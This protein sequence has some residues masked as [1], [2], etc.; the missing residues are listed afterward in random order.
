MLGL[1]G[2]FNANGVVCSTES[3]LVSFFILESSFGGAR[4]ALVLFVEF[5]SACDWADR[6]Y[7]LGEGEGCDACGGC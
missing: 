3:S 5:G 6:I 2:V 1:V 4:S 7:R